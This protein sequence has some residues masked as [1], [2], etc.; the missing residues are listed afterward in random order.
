MRTP[1]NLPLKRVI[2]GVAAAGLLG[3]SGVALAEEPSPSSPPGVTS[4]GWALHPAG[5]QIDLADS[6]WWADRP[7]GQGLSPKGR[8]LIVS[9]AGASN[10]SVKLVDT[11]S[12][13]VKQT[14]AYVAPEAV[15][16]GVV[17][18]PDGTRAFVSGGG[19]DKIRTYTFNG[20]HLTEGPSIPTAGSGNKGASYP[21]GLAISKDGTT[22][23]AAEN[24]LDTL[25]VVDLASAAVTHV[26]VGTCNEQGGPVNSGGAVPQCQP[27]GVTLSPD[28]SKAYVS[29]W[30]EE[31]ISVINT[32]TRS[33]TGQIRAG[34][35][36]HPSALRTNPQ[37][38]RHQAAVTNG[39]SD[40]LSIINTN[41]DTVVRTIDL[42]PYRNAPQGSQPDALAFAP[43]GNTLYVANAGNN[44]VDVIGLTG[45]RE[46]NHGSILGMIPTAWYPSAVDVSP[47]GRSLYIANAKGM[48]AGPNEGY[49]QGQYRPPNQYV[50]SMMHG[51]LQIVSAPRGDE[52]NGYTQQVVRTNGFD[53]R[54]NARVAAGEGS[55]VIPR[56]VGDP[57][58]IKHIIYVVKENRTYDQVFGNLEKGNG[59]PDLT[60]FGNDSAP[61]IRNL[62]RRFVL[63]DN[64]YAASEVSADG[65]SWSTEA[66]ANTYDQKTWPANYSDVNRGRG[67]DWEGGNY[68]SAAN[69]NPK[70]SYLWDR[71]ADQ[72]IGFQNFGFWTIF[73]STPPGVAAQPTEPRLDA[74]TDRNYEGYNLA[75]ADSPKAPPVL[76]GGQGPAGNCAAEA[77]TTT[78]A[79]ICA[80]IQNFLANGLPAV[81]F[82]RLPNDHTAGT[83]AGAPVPKTYVADNDYAVGLLVQTISHSSYWKDTAIFVTEDDAQDGP[84]HVDGHRSE[85]LVISPYTQTGKVDSTFYST[86]SM[87]R[88]IELI[89]G[90]H[91]MTQYDA[92]A[93]PMLKAFSDDTNLTP[94]EAVVPAML[95]SP[96]FNAPTAPLAAQMQGLSM[97]QADNLP[98]SV[99]NAAIWKSVRGA[100]SSLPGGDPTGD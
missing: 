9:S 28:G 41:T 59:D 26:S 73:G 11:T 24:R 29:N 14:I 5:R 98:E 50:G 80:W 77:G 34:I 18:S 100:D 49:Q 91:P 86:V 63:L 88:T 13:K 35:G 99:L 23:Y 66:T 55:S 94:Y 46:E 1:T 22:L 53:E 74:K 82:V 69:K 76:T 48:G 67:Y 15:N 2:T 43:D 75:W 31:S 20:S 3:A 42:A 79:R 68:A 10:E 37:A 39:D 44:D 87:L 12:G 32:A 57:S 56:R 70:D 45:E 52:L 85:S 19:D 78:K 65:W 21:M 8:W 61:N 17:W 25:A 16:V 96:A 60:L 84:D 64:Y 47:T 36:T 6:V 40:T 58:P 93:T 7:Y 38:A 54:A 72:N 83:R 4:Y 90:V 71:L 97:T 89:V 30:G 62:A 95:A 92:A 51:T 27:Y 33:L 81:E